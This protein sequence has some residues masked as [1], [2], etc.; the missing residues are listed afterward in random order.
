MLAPHVSRQGANRYL[1]FACAVVAVATYVAGRGDWQNTPLESALKAAFF[2]N[3]ILLVG[4]VATHLAGALRR[5]RDDSTDRKIGN[6]P[7]P[8]ERAR[9][10]L[11]T[12]WLVGA[13]A[14]VIA[15]SPG[16]AVRHVLIAL[17]V[18]LLV[19]ARL[20]RADS[21]SNA[22]GGEHPG[23]GRA[24]RG[25]GRGWMRAAV[26]ATAV[27]GV[28]FGLSDWRYADVYRRQAPALAKLQA[29]P[30]R[31]LWQVGHWGW[32][33][34]AAGADMKQY[35]ASRSEPAAGDRLIVPRLVD[36]QSLA[37]RHEKRLRRIARNAVPASPATWLR[38][39]AIGP[40]GG[41]GLY[42]LRLD[43]LPWT[44]TREP[45]EHFDVFEF[46]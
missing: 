38:T 39:M 25:A 10:I 36:K 44:L 29:A 35:D 34:Y 14:V 6:E 41:Y 30:G 2:A 11:F 20:G 3:G 7:M 18:L 9:A 31:T 16:M 32:Q 13:A 23:V 33:W 27:S 4:M 15:F 12:A 40:R 17:P 21:T 8:P 43:T 19:S 42:A 22:V 45:L 5:P 46:R 37:P 1:L 24:E 28:L 26:A